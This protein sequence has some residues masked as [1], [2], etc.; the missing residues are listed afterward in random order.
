MEVWVFGD[1]EIRR[2]GDSE[3]WKFE[4]FLETWKFYNLKISREFF[5]F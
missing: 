2:F 4:D 3:I 5:F 1:L